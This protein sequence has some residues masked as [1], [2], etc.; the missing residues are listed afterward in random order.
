MAQILAQLCLAPKFNKQNLETS[1][2]PSI[3][4]SLTLGGVEPLIFHKCEKRSHRGT[5][6]QLGF[7]V[8]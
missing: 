2:L 8:A 6:K 4:D 1:I 3:S 7:L 5:E